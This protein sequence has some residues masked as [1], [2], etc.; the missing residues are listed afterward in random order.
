MKK[1]NIENLL[2]NSKNLS[3]FKSALLFEANNYK[4]YFKS[5]R[6]DQKSQIKENN[7]RFMGRGFG[8][9]KCKID[10]EVGNLIKAKLNELSVNYP[11]DVKEYERKAYS[12]DFFYV[13]HRGA[14]IDNLIFE[15]RII[16]PKVVQ[17]SEFSFNIPIE[18]ESQLTPLG[19]T[20]LSLDLG[21]NINNKKEIY[22]AQ[23]NEDGTSELIDF[24]SIKKED[25]C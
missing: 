2:K 4:E 9:Q 5:K 18:F 24:S 23:V 10:S 13:R 17:R 20:P 12:E 3:E 25:E 6:N 15:I 8:W 1:L 21:E 11:E 22:Q 14:H 7:L 19:G 16:D